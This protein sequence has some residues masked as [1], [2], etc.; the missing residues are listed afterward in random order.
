MTRLRKITVVLTL[1]IIAICFAGCQN[2]SATFSGNKNGNDTQPSLE[3]TEPAVT[4]QPTEPVEQVEPS[5]TTEPSEPTEPAE[6]PGSVSTPTVAIMPTPPFSY[7]ISDSTTGKE[8]PPIRLEMVSSEP[9]EIID[10]DNWFT[11]NDLSS[12]LN[13]NYA[14]DGSKEY[15]F[16]GVGI[17]EGNILNI[18]DAVQNEL[19]YSIDFSNYK[20]S[21]QY[22]EED[23]DFIEQDIKCAT[24]KD[25]ILYVNH[26]HS[27]YAKSSK[28]MNAY[29]TAI[30]LSDM[31]V[32]WRSDA[33]VCNSKDFLI[34][35][36]VI[37]SGYG[38]TDE[39]DYLYQ[40]D[41]KTGKTID[42][43]SLKSA[44]E[45]IIM[46]DS[47]LYVRTYNTDYQF[48]IE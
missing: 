6:L 18:Y 29:I 14:K 34:V 33:L 7:Y 5:I 38:F 3:P 19:L 37:I 13:Q 48:V 32:I 17:N 11:E 20:Y 36:D 26:S 4:V 42:R 2:S 27:T 23:Y 22:K 40:I 46:K 15:L 30:N 25:D 47:I 9:N 21:P 8:S 31:S 1:F 24:I 12:H 28:N 39:P 10:I 16:D 45:Y 35:D 41:R 43:L 44:P